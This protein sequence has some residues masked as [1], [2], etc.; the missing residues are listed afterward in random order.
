M[1]SPVTLSHGATIT[2]WCSALVVKLE[3]KTQK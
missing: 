1:A 3:L 2:A